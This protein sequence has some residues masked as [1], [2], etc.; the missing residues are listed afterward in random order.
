MRRIFRRKT[1]FD[2]RLDFAPFCQLLSTHS[3]RHFEGVTFD[4]S[5]DGMRKGMFF[6]S[7]IELL[8]YDDFL[9]CLTALE[10]DGNLYMS[11]TK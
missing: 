9:A 8:D 6:G 1:H 2:E 5:Y 3:F 7:L 4:T 11:K 10:N